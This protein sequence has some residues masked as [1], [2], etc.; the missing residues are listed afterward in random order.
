MTPNIQKAFGF[1]KHD[2]M[3]RNC[4]NSARRTRLS[5]PGKNSTTIW[6]LNGPLS[7]DKK[8]AYKSI[9]KSVPNGSFIHISHGTEVIHVNNILIII[10]PLDDPIFSCS[11]PVIKGVGVFSSKNTV[12]TVLQKTHQ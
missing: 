2:L 8:R 11:Q 6:C 10:K 9:C 3:E 5:L 12:D 1:L 7:S 4:G